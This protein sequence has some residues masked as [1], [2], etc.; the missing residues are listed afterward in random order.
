MSLV[1]TL[2]LRWF[3]EVD[4]QIEVETGTV[5]TEKFDARWPHLEMIGRKGRYGCEWDTDEKY[6]FMMDTLSEGPCF[7]IS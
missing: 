3:S 2:R 4:A 1:R 5:D 6:Q 7:K